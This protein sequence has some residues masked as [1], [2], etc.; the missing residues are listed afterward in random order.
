MGS[1]VC[2]LL[3]DFQRAGEVRYTHIMTLVHASTGMPCLYVTSEC[4]AQ[5][6]IVGKGSHFLCSFDHAGHHNFGCDDDWEDPVRFQ[7]AALQVIRRC[8]ELPSEQR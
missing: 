7:K 1:Y 5:G 6:P 2:Y 3:K 4:N 8:I